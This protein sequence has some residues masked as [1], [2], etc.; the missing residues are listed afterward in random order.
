MTV[1]KWI[2]I[3]GAAWFLLAILV[4]VGW[5]VVVTDIKRSPQSVK[6]VH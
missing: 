6:R 3:V 1:L 2:G 5:S 4:T